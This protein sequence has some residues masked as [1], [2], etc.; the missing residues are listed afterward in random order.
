MHSVN[1]TK[2]LFDRY[3]EFT[4][5]AQ[6][7]ELTYPFNLMDNLEVNVIKTGK[8]LD[9]LS[10]ALKQEISKKKTG[11]GESNSDNSLDVEVYIY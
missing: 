3:I 5:M 2:Q 7:H 11:L 9:D 4:S 1:E 8:I 10:K 6:S